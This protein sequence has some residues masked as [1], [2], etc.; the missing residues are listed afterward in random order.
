MWRAF[1]GEII[2][3]LKDRRVLALLFGMPL[4]VTLFFGYLYINHKVTEIPTVV[5]DQDNS[6]LS[7]ST[8]SAFDRSEKFAVTGYASSREE[9]ELLMRQG[10]AYAAVI[11]PHDFA[12]D[13]KTGRATG[14]LIIADGSNMIISNT[15]ATGAA[16]VVGSISAGIQLQRLEA[17]GLPRD[18][19]EDMVQAVSF[20]SRVWYNPTYNYLKFLLPGLIVMGMQQ[21]LFITTAIVMFRSGPPAEAVDIQSA[22]PCGAVGTGGGPAAL[23]VK[24]LPCA[25]LGTVVLLCCLVLARV[26]FH[27]PLGGDFFVL[28]LLTA[29]FCLGTAGL[30]ALVA[31]LTPTL[32]L[33][34]QLAMVIAAPAF[35]ISGFTWPMAAIPLPVRVLAEMVPLTHYLDAMRAVAMKGAGLADASRQLMNMVFI[36]C[37]LAFINILVLRLKTW[38][39][40]RGVSAA[41]VE[42]TR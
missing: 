4:A 5:M 25:L 35:L 2:F 42:K 16:E 26:I 38:R 20:S 28:A 8:A 31:L 33:A 41:Q 32:D 11:I 22:A 18:R 21:A 24:I 12:R 29:V 17:T 6:S 40:G 7:R 23:L 1:C 13:V 9:I 37:A 19:A 39:A 14:V 27:L 10:R 36:T 34:I 30:G 15:I 3:M